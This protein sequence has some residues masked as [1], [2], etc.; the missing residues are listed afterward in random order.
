MY[1]N[2]TLPFVGN[3]APFPRP[4]RWSDLRADEAE[5][6][7]RQRIASDSHAKVIFTHHTW[8]RVSEREIT[9]GDVYRILEEGSCHGQPVK[10][11]HGHWQVTMTKRIL[12]NREAGAVTII[13]QE[14]EELIIRT[15]QWM[16]VR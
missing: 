6:I 16:D 5:R 14:K 3:V 15:V 8:E 13:I 12:G 4:I 11:E 9:R 7:I 2:D 1:Q 10:S